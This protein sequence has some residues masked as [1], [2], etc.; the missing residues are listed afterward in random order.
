M[1]HVNPK[2]QPHALGF[3][4][5]RYSAAPLAY[6]S[7]PNDFVR[8][9][10][11]RLPPGRVLCLGEGQG[12]NAVFLAQRGFDVTAM[13][14]SR[15]GLGRAEALAAEHGVRIT[16]VAADLAEFMIEPLAFAAIVSVF[17]H[18]SLPLR[19]EVHERVMHGLAEGGAYV[20]EQY[21]PDQNH[22]KTGGPDELEKRPGLET[23]RPE[24]SKLDFEIG[25]EVVRDV[26]EG[27]YHTGLASTVQILA[28][29]PR[30]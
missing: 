17:V 22:Y 12:R 6:G 29:R 8:E 10:A 11:D 27:V 16:T 25:R 14:Q 26:T 5:E 3:W 9:V 1:S 20:F 4:D 18:L 30:A 7:E 23:L 24:L 13:D 28:R 2:G 19:R 15:I 21:G